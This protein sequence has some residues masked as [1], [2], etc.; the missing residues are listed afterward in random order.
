MEEQ[1]FRKIT[2]ERSA[3][4]RYELSIQASLDGFLFCVHTPDTGEI[5]WWKSY[6]WEFTGYGQLLRKIRERYDT[7][8]WSTLK[9][10]QVTISLGDP[11]FVLIPRPLF[12]D[13]AASRLLAGEKFSTADTELVMTPLEPL[14]A[15]MAFPVHE[16]LAAFFRD[17][18][19]G[20]VI[21][22]EIALLLR[23]FSQQGPNGLFVHLHDHWF[24]VICIRGGR[25]DVVNTFDYR[26]E[27]DLLFYL[28]SFLNLPGYE[29]DPVTLSGRI[30]VQDSRY[31]LLKNHI[32]RITLFTTE[33]PSGES[34]P[35]TEIPA[36]LLPGVI[37][38]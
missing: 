7:E 19:P 16:P 33:Y 26:S 3:C 36:Q 31:V 1:E 35:L 29:T 13:K 38:I 6:H 5:L 20:C 34:I 8:D 25:P 28:L 37:P 18:H 4:S 17:H 27:T 15:V 32:P 23:N 9:F 24:S 30:Y 12:S 14:D 10:G 21:S 22:H 2:F 11:R